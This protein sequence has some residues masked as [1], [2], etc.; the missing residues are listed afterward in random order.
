MKVAFDDFYLRLR[1]QPQ[2]II[3]DVGRTFGTNM[4]V[5]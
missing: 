3:R 1:T 4:S 5:S 2:Q